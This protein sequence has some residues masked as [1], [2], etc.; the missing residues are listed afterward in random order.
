MS[1]YLPAN[2]LTDGELEQLIKKANKAYRS[3]QPIMD[4]SLYDHEYLAEFRRR[5]P[6]HKLFHRVEV[7][8]FF[9][10][11]KGQTPNPDVKHG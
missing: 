8:P 5:Y 1:I 7:E 4:D 3:G 11:T 2:E 9:F 10:R 6:D